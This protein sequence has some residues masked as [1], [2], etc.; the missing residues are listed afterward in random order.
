MSQNRWKYNVQFVQAIHF[1]ATNKRWRDGLQDET[2]RDIV[3]TA[4]LGMEFEFL[5][6]GKKKGDGRYSEEK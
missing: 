3:K 2:K 1:L 5:E 4:Q 6:K